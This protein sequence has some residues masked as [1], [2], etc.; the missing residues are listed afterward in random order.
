MMTVRYSLFLMAYGKKLDL[1]TIEALQMLIKA[2]AS[3][4]IIV[5]LLRSA[6][7][8]TSARRNS[9]CA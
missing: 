2:T 3:T 9:I 1:M 8:V 6:S 5:T 4:N 7:K